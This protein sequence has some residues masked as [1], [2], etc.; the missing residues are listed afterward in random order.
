MH[1][2]CIIYAFY[3]H[4]VTR[5]GPF[6][7]TGCALQAHVYAAAETLPGAICSHAWLMSFGLDEAQGH[8]ES[9]GFSRG[10]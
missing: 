4:T 5:L 7:S 10:P 1:F 2:L 6:N 3:V 9:F 8:L